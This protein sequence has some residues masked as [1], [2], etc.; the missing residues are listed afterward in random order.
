M[1][2]LTTTIGDFHF[3]NTVMNGA[4][5]WCFDRDE[6]SAVDSSAAATFV[7]KTATLQARQGNPEPRM[8]ATSLG[9]IN[10]MGLPNKGLD[11]YLGVLAEFENTHPDKPYF[12][13]TTGTD[14]DD[15]GR[16]FTKI[17][18]SNFHGLVE[19]NLSCPNV[20]GK[21]QI[22]YDFGAVERILTQV[23]GIYHGALGVKL[24]PYFDLVH[25]QEIAA[26]LNKFP[27]VFVNTINSVGNGLV[28][29][30]ETAAI[31]P[32]GGLGGIGGGYIKPM[33]L[34]NV[35]TLRQ[36]LNP[37][38]RIIGTGGVQNG[39]DVFELILCGADMVGVAT[40]L[41]K[42]GPKVFARLTQ[43]LSDLMDEKGYR[44]LSDFRGKL[45]V[46]EAVAVR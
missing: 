15:F 29:K 43:E 46:P 36:L 26:V 45:Q 32:K 31:A 6:L 40:Q 7:T 10:S 5:V 13:S 30:D 12:L 23:T 24:P 20:V 14:P 11:Y 8:A 21:P 33:A 17:A 42:E 27:L 41:G 28:I 9:S 35:R 16:L 2:D 44:R 3:D 18:Q 4:G 19:L 1:A 39:R 25:F 22:A 34:A 38:I 37:S